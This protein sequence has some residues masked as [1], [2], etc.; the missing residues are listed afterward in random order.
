MESE[1]EAVDTATAAAAAAIASNA[2][3]RWEP[4][5]LAATEEVVAIASAWA[6]GERPVA[7][8]PGDATSSAS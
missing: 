5:S 1:F 6:S 4:P 2:A 7:A 8:E 3:S